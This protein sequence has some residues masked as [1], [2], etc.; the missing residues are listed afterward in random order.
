MPACLP[1]VGRE[2]VGALPNELQR[3]KFPQCDYCKGDIR[4]ILSSTNTFND[5]NS[6]AHGGYWCS[7]IRFHFMKCTMVVQVRRLEA[8]VEVV[9]VFAPKL[10]FRCIP[11]DG[12]DVAGRQAACSGDIRY[13]HTRIYLN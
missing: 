12:K 6:L 8:A 2:L 10:V 13:S 5:T 1:G 9:I 11:A 3:Y 4:P 7:V